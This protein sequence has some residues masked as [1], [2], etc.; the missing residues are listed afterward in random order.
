[1]SRH[2]RETMDAYLLGDGA[3][4]P[5]PSEI[6]EIESLPGRVSFAPGTYVVGA[7]DHL[8]PAGRAYV[9][10]LASR[11]AACP[12][13]RLLNHP[14]KTLT[15]FDLLAEL[16][17]HGYARQRVARPNGDV[18]SLRFPVMVRSG[19]SHL[20]PLSPLLHSAG[21]VRGYVGRGVLLG[22]G[23]DDLM[24]VEYLDTSDAQGYFRKYAA[25]VVGGKILARS[26]SIGRPWV[27]KYGGGEASVV[28][29]NEELEFVRT[30]PH[31]PQLAEIAR[32]AR[33]EY[34]RVDYAVVNG[35]VNV[36]E[37]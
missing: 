29:A 21:E 12:G 19:A 27:L 23:M 28:H 13:I 5:Y 1:M 10:Q 24:A 35:R 2:N 32:I 8:T 20:G 26:L 36:W 18:A 31:E 4:R 16:H 9:A 14:A 34:G 3:L 17:R 22:Y 30:N 6:V 37:I 33:I 25:Y 15:R 7:G 11:L